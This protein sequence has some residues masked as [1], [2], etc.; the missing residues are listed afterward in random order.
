MRDRKE[1]NVDGTGGGKEVGG[2]DFGEAMIRI[3]YVSKEYI[4]N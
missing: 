3:C 4:Y 1:M 2:V